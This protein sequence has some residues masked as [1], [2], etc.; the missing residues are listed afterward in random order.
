MARRKKPQDETVEQTTERRLREAIANHATRS[1]KMS[2]DRKM[3]GMVRLLAK[4]RPLED[5]LL[6]ILAEKQPILDDIAELRAEMVR[7]CIHP[8]DHLV[9]KEGH[10]YCK[11]CGKKISTAQLDK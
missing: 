2:W 7:E 1:E 11:F 9:I 3:D 10:A 4:L 5:R 8:Y 6:D